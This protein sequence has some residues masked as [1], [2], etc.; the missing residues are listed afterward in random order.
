MKFN[1]KV[2]EYIKI[3]N[4]ECIYRR[5]TIKRNSEELNEQFITIY[6]LKN[7][8]N[9]NVKD[10]ELTITDIDIKRDIRSFVSYAV[11]C[12]FGRYS[13]DGEGLIYA[14]GEWDRSRYKTFLPDDDNCIPITDEEYFSDDI[15][16]RFVE[17][18]KN[19]LRSRYP[20]RKSGFYCQG[21]RQ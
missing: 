9:I 16:G 18:V 17:F 15:V 2:E 6:D 3:W 8:L 13:L 21:F 19:R 10:D 11:G 7:E 14:G 12:M 20:G 1:G 5:K 4:E